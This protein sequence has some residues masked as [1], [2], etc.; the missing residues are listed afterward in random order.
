MRQ[1]IKGIPLAMW[2]SAVPSQQLDNTP[3]AQQCWWQK[4]RNDRVHATRDI[5]V[6]ATNGW[7]SQRT[8]TLQHCGHWTANER[9][10]SGLGAI[11]P[12]KLRYSIRTGKWV[13]LENFQ[14]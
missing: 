9:S 8:K 14:I 7:V 3:V 1:T 13:W 11:E 4:L 5:V 6:C 2:N 12:T 10:H